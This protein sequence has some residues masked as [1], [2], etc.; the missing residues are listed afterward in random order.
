[1]TTGKKWS[2][3]AL[4]RARRYDPELCAQRLIELSA[5]SGNALE[6]E[7]SLML[8]Q[9]RVKHLQQAVQSL[10]RSGIAAAKAANRA[11]LLIRTAPR[12][13]ADSERPSEG[14]DLRCLERCS[15]RGMSA[16]VVH[17]RAALEEAAAAPPSQ[18]LK[19]IEDSEL[20]D[21][22]LAGLEI[23]AGNKTRRRL[24]PNGIRAIRI[25]DMGRWKGLRR[26]TI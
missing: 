10:E 19:R 1:M 16:V 11:T 5:I 13:S 12:L 14:S 22:V 23:A 18:M 9:G 24:I 8:S 26:N 3:A 17:V 15:N 21:V 25:C 2:K 20:R 6:K 4:R 7:L